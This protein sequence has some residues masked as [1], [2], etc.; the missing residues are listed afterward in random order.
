MTVLDQN[1]KSACLFLAVGAFLLRARG[2]FLLFVRVH[3]GGGVVS[4]GRVSLFVAGAW[5]GRVSGFCNLRPPYSNSVSKMFTYYFERTHMDVMNFHEL[6]HMD[7]N[8]IPTS[9][10]RMSAD[11]KRSSEPY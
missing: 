3:R 6:I 11:V 2:A 7:F 4:F 9:L 5:G 10:N 1:G 8:R